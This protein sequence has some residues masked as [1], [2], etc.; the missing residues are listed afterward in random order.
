MMSL[1]CK[2]MSM[3]PSFEIPVPQGEAR[4]KELILYISVRCQHDPNFGA[5]KLN[6]I[7]W[8]SDFLAYLRLGEPITGVAY[9][10]LP[11]GPVPRRFPALQRELERDGRVRIEERPSF[12]DRARK[13]TV[14]L[15]NANLVHFTG[16]QI[17]IVH[18]AIE[19][20]AGLNAAETSDRTHGI[21]WSLAKDE[22][23]IPYEA[24]FLAEP[25]PIDGLIAEDLLEEHDI[26]AQNCTK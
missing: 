26:R 21:A 9:R 10:K 22:E 2:V 20:Y 16:D 6:K 15:E 12:G 1:V 3:E 7:L 17:A 18:E 11:W 24:A 25:D 5:T 23:G 19:E 4:F 14:A 13:V 8:R